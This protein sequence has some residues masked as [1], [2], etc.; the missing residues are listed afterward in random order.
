MARAGVRQLA[1]AFLLVLAL[2]AAASLHGPGAAT[3]GGRQVHRDPMAGALANVE[4]PAHAHLNEPLAPTCGSGGVI[5]SLGVGSGAPT[6]TSCAASP[7]ATLRSQ[8]L[9][10]TVRMGFGRRGPPPC[11]LATATVQR[12]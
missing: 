7:R 1:A 4:R 6:V 2:A 10:T 12:C 11:D 3:R 9:P 8:R 5:E